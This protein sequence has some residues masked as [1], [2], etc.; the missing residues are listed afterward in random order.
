MPSELDWPESPAPSPFG[1]PDYNVPGEINPGITP[2]VWSTIAGPH[3]GS[4][5]EQAQAEFEA[6]V[7]HPR[8]GIP[9][10]LEANLRR[11]LFSPFV[12]GLQQGLTAAQAAKPPQSRNIGRVLVERNPLTEVW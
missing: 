12:V 4:G 3:Q 11:E 1:W 6:R 9:D 5:I 10:D 7:A 2:G 8:S